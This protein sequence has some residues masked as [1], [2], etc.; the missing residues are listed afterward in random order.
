MLKIFLILY[1]SLIAE[2]KQDIIDEYMKYNYPFVDM[3]YIQNIHHKT[4][5]LLNNSTIAINDDNFPFVDVY[6]LFNKK[7]KLPLD[8]AKKTHKLQYHARQFDINGYK[9]LLLQI[10]YNN[11]NFF[12]N[13]FNEKLSHSTYEINKSVISFRFINKTHIDINYEKEL[14]LIEKNNNII[15]KKYENMLRNLEFIHQ[16]KINIDKLSFYSPC[17]GEIMSN[18]NI[19]LLLDF[20][21]FILISRFV[22]ESLY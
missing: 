19:I 6:L 13:I 4:Q 16:I 18:H 20:M 9:S 1:I 22:F 21:I 10:S 17:T 2:K 14:K 15:C 11:L 7:R 8:I 12:E 3:S 5:N